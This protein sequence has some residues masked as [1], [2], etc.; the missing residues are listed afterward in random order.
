MRSLSNWRSIAEFHHRHFPACPDDGFY[1]EGYSDLV[2]RTLAEDWHSLPELSLA[3]S[4]NAEFQRFVL[5]HIDAST[6]PTQLKTVLTRASFSCP[7]G[8]EELCSAIAEAAKRAIA[9][10]R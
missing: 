2:V 8:Q 1:A 10:L 4:R 9:D 5:K 6:D 3:I 7:E